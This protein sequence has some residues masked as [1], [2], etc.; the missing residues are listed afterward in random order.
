MNS[1]PF[2]AGVRRASAVFLLLA[3]ALAGGCA[4]KITMETASIKTGRAVNASGD[5]REEEDDFETTDVAAV[6][7]AEFL[8]VHGSH[9][10]RFQWFNDEDEL[11][12]DSGPVPLSPDASK[13][14]DVRR[15]WSVLPIHGHPPAQMTGDWT[16]KVLL[17]GK[18]LDELE[19][20][21][22]KP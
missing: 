14:Y 8:N 10:V 1:M 20:E 16:I 4:T 21:I 7:W 22:D 18:P 5:L 15:A 6:A 2:L 3:A 12:L 17:D 9:Q 13:L 11:V 19:I